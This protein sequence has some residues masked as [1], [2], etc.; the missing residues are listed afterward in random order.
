MC[1]D[2]KVFLALTALKIY[3]GMLLMTQLKLS[4]IFFHD[5]IDQYNLGHSLYLNRDRESCLY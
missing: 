5:Q 3:P 4:V 2:I 1:S